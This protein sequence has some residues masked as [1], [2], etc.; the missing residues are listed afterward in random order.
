[1]KLIENKV[2]HW[3][4]LGSTRMAE[5]PN[6]RMLAPDG[7]ELDCQHALLGEPKGIPRAREI[8]K[9]KYDRDYVIR[10]I[11]IMLRYLIPALKK[12]EFLRLMT[13]VYDFERK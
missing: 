5:N 8:R 9:V 12:D 7:Y 1:M 6:H 11:S 2:Y 13:E 4:D 10:K 3:T